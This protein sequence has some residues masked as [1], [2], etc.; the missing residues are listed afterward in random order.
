[1]PGFELVGDHA[2]FRPTGQVS[3]EQVSQLVTAAITSAREQ[4]IQKL[5]VVTT[6][7]KDLKSPGLASRYYFVADWARAAAGAVCVALVLQPELIDPQKFGVSVAAS[8]GLKSD[9]FVSEPEALAY[10]GNLTP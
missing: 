10:L 9:V 7:L 6:G 1:M 2:E 5:L 8:L 3:L 4:Q